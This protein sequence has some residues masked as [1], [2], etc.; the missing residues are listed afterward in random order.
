MTFGHFWPSYFRILRTDLENEA[1][2]KNSFLRKEELQPTNSQNRYKYFSM[3]ARLTKI[4]AINK[5]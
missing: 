4:Q 5:L 3:P 1:L 2:V